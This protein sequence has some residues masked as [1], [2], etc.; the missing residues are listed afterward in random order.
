MGGKIGLSQTYY[1]TTSASFPSGPMARPV[2]I[3]R[4]SG[5][6]FQENFILLE[7]KSKPFSSPDLQA[8]STNSSPTPDPPLNGSPT[9][10]EGHAQIREVRSHFFL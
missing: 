10:L 4:S 2:T 3:I 9:G 7:S 5:K 6:P 8:V 1:T